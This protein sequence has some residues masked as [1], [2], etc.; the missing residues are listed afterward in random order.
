MHQ[1]TLE[2]VLKKSEDLQ[3][4]I[5]K[6]MKKFCKLQWNVTLKKPMKLL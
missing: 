2:Y 5:L 3:C 6:V 1:F 4:L